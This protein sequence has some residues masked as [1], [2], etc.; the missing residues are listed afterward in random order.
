MRKI[1]LG[2]VLTLG[3]MLLTPASAPAIVNGTNATVDPGVVSLWTDNPNRNRCSGALVDDERGGPGTRWVYTA[4]HCIFAFTEDDPAAGRVTARLGSTSNTTGYTAIKVVPGQFWYHPGFLTDTLAYD[5]MLVLLE[6]ETPANVPV[7]KWRKPSLPIGGIAQ[8]YGYGWTCDGG[9]GLPCGTWYAGPVKT[10]QPKRL[11]AT[12]CFTHY[13]PSQMCFGHWANGYVM[14]CNGDSGGPIKAID[15]TGQP[16]LTGG[17]IGDGDANWDSCTQG[18]DGAP[19]RGLA[20]DIGRPDIQ[21][22]MDDVMGGTARQA[23]TA[24]PEPTPR[25]LQMIN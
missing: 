8:A 14:A 3:A 22:W 12:D 6:D 7:M 24:L 4:A 23:R 1:I 10:M 19:G 2:A 20:L 18:L 25:I 21:T 5:G 9:A 17:I 15:F 13:D 16:I 11:P